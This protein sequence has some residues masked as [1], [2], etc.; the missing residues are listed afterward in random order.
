VSKS[1][2]GPKKP[3][4][5]HNQQP[6]D[7]ATPT[8]PSPK[9]HDLPEY[10][11][12]KPHSSDSSTHQA[13]V[14]DPIRAYLSS[15]GY[16]EKER[17]DFRR[18]FVKKSNEFDS[19]QRIQSVVDVYRLDDGRLDLSIE[20][21]VWSAKDWEGVMGAV[22][23]IY[24]L[25]VVVESTEPLTLLHP[26]NVVVRKVSFASPGAIVFAG[27][28]P[29]VERVAR[30]VAK[31]FE[32]KKSHYDESAKREKAIAVALSNLTVAKSLKD[33]GVLSEDQFREYSDKSILSILELQRF[34]DMEKITD[35][36]LFNRN[37]LTTLDLFRGEKEDKGN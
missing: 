18:E 26:T 21:T 23:G 2:E 17:E 31:L 12:G 22:N 11:L 29:A 36:S 25:P 27:L 3:R 16:S 30:T 37:K 5:T 32:F 35:F 6:A 34:M 1:N 10:L 7:S 24:H 15:G 9:G 33:A 4:S 20:G 19:V 14:F 28:Y 13:K 8:P